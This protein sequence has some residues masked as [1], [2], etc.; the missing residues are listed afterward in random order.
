MN[1]QSI[2]N[3]KCDKHAEEQLA[4]KRKDL[5]VDYY[6]KNYFQNIPHNSSK[7]RHRQF[8]RYTSIQT[9]SNEY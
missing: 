3:Y 4:N 2:I 5:L 8:Y 1:G 6:S 9:Q 7:L